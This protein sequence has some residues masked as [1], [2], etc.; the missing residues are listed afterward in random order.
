[1]TEPPLIFVDVDGTLL[2]F[3]AAGDYPNFGRMDRGH[4][5]RLLGLGGEL[6]WATAWMGEANDVIGPLLGLPELPVVDLPA[7]DDDFV[8][9]GLCWKTQKLVAHAAGRP[10]VWLDDEPTEADDAY[11]AA[12]HSGPAL[13]YRTDPEIGLTGADFDAI[14]AWLRA[15]SGPDALGA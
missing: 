13:L 4:G 1:M 12:H 6:W 8:D 9:E 7:W 15:H 3:G 5:P 10:F 11:V 14:A 2:P